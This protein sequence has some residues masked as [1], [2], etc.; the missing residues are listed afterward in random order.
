MQT[1]GTLTNLVT[2]Q[3]HEIVAYVSLRHHE[4]FDSTQLD[5]RH[6]SSWWGWSG[7]MFKNSKPDIKIQGP[8]LLHLYDGNEDGYMDFVIKFI[9]EQSKAA[10]FYT[11]LSY[12]LQQVDNFEAMKLASH[13]GRK[14]DNVH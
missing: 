4:R 12:E 10:G 5:A 14:Y 13:Y 3:V 7:V 8:Y 1:C 11:G 6:K 2:N 9:S